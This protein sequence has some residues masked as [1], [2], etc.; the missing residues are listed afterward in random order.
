MRK[1]TIPG[2]R[3]GEKKYQKKKRQKEDNTTAAI[4]KSS[5]EEATI[6]VG[7]NRYK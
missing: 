2:K 4:Y 6:K 7:K 5:G 3:K 1:D